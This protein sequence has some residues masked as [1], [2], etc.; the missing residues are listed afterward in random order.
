[1]KKRVRTLTGI[2][3][4]GLFAVG[5]GD[6]TVGPDPE[7]QQYQVV[8]VAFRSGHA[9]L[10]DVPV[11]DT[12]DVVFS[13]V[14]EQQEQNGVGGLF[15]LENA[16]GSP[17]PVTIG[18][19]SGSH[20]WFAPTSALEPATQYV[21]DVTSSAVAGSYPFPLTF[22]TVGIPPDI[23]GLTVRS[24]GFLVDVS[25]VQDYVLQGNSGSGWVD[26]TDTLPASQTANEFVWSQ[27]PEFNVPTQI[28]IR[29]VG[30]GF[31]SDS[32]TVVPL[33]STF[34]LNSATGNEYEMF[35]DDL[36]DATSGAAEGWM[37]G[38]FYASQA[39]FVRTTA[40]S[41]SPMMDGSHIRIIDETGAVVLGAFSQEPLADDDG[42]DGSF[43]QILGIRVPADGTYYVHVRPDNTS[44]NQSIWMPDLADHGWI[45][46]VTGYIVM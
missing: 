26:I 18:W 12:V 11:D 29:A 15:T 45:Y 31:T 36:G 3:A 35:L 37:K 34:L 43:S 30:G 8:S 32:L 21:F 46:L 23:G 40:H 14:L 13:R 9:S 5:C 17:V 44:P 6:E 38:D 39:Y 22:T 16:D 27:M 20:A 42:G 25:S 7:F 41:E 33:V 19:T 2:L 10:Q 28:D 4:V 1:M 24:Y